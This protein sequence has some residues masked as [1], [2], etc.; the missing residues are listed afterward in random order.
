MKPSSDIEKPALT[1]PMFILLGPCEGY[2]REYL[3]FSLR[4]C[5]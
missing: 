4:S 5:R 1:F 2:L 3:C